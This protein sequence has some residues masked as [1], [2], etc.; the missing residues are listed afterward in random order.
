MRFIPGHNRDLLRETLHRIPHHDQ[1]RARF[2]RFCLHGARR[3][4][5]AACA[6]AGECPSRLTA[7]HNV[8]VSGRRLFFRGNRRHGRAARGRREPKPP[9][10]IAP[11]ATIFA[12]SCCRA[13]ASPNELCRVRPARFSRSRLP[14][15][16]QRAAPT[17]LHVCMGVTWPANGRADPGSGEWITSGPE[18]TNRN[19]PERSHR[20]SKPAR[21][22]HLE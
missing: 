4:Y 1:I 22:V 11:N 13:A 5:A 18:H 21:V 7:R 15:E 12:G 20:R 8:R 6:A 10:G 17:V 14:C 3:F 16:C 2:R 9:V 19:E